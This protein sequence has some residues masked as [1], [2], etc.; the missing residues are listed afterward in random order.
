MENPLPNSAILQKSARNNFLA[1]CVFWVTVSV[2]YLPA[3]KAGQVGDFTGW[4]YTIRYGNF[5]DFINRPDSLS[6]YQFTQF[7]SYFF[8]KLFG[9][10]PLLWHLLQT[11]LHAVNCF[12]VF[13][14]CRRLMEDA[15]I[16]NAGKI[17]FT[18][19]FLF[20]LCPLN[21]EVVVHEPCYHY[22]QGYLI[23]LLILRWL[24]QF[25]H[26]PKAKYAVW[27]GVLYLLSTYSLEVFYLTPW[28]VLSMSLYY[29]LALGYDRRIFRQAFLWFFLPLLLMYLAH[30][31]V[32]HTVIRVYVAHVAPPHDIFTIAY[33]CKLPEYLFHVVFLGR[34]FPND[35]RQHAYNICESAWFLIAFY[36]FLIAICGYIAVYFKK[37]TSKW[38]VG[39]LFLLWML[40]MVF[41]VTPFAIPQLQL[42]LFDRYTY[43]MQ[44]F[45]FVLV[46]LMISGRRFGYLAI[47]VL[48]AYA[49]CLGGF[50]L[51]T[52]YYW[53]RSSYIVRRLIHEVPDPANKIV[54]LLNP[55]ENMNGILMIG[56]QPESVWKLMY[57]L[58]R[59]KKLTNTVYDVASYNMVSPDDGAHVNVLNDSMLTVTLN[60]WGTWWWYRYKGGASYENEAYKLNMTDV[61]HRYELTLKHP[62][63]QYLIL[64]QSGDRWKEVDVNN[65]NT[66]QY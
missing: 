35:L 66:D 53:K 16:S 54:V 60:Q 46:A 32:L 20:A 6:L 5:W 34:Y 55:P 36:G 61:G 4:L 62:A 26:R 52:N 27:A 23:V 58:Y 40:F 31:I 17:A 56:S 18:G 57:N 1:F 12:L 14:L 50:L 48:S 22:L 42:V 49:V 7:V 15:A 30:V 37:L 25:H 13:L 9:A 63:D 3:A 24:Q 43:F 21:T 8:Y 51:K 28:L 59:D 2:F 47:A 29:R 44:P 11:T 38:K 41:L 64:Y 19:A 39:G 10:N 33:L 45:I 65:K